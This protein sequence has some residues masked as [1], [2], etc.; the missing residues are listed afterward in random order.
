M[1]KQTKPSVEHTYVLQA[2][3]ILFILLEVEDGVSLTYR[4][5]SSP[6][7]RF[8]SAELCVVPQVRVPIVTT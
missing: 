5:S 1:N 6:V 7:N 4:R 2:V 3:Q 8:R